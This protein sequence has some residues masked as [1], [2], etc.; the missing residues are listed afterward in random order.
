VDCHIDSALLQGPLKLMH[1]HAISPQTGDRCVALYITC[2]L[3]DFNR[4]ITANCTKLIR[5]MTS[6][7][8]SQQTATGAE[9]NTRHRRLTESEKQTEETVAAEPS[10]I[11]CGS[12]PR[13]FCL[14]DCCNIHGSGSSREE[15]LRTCCE[16][17]SR[18]DHIIY[19]Q[20]IQVSSVTT[21]LKNSGDI[22][23]PLSRWKGILHARGPDSSQLP[24]LGNAQESSDRRGHHIRRTCAS[25]DPPPPVHRNGN[26]SL[27]ANRRKPRLHKQRQST[28]DRYGDRLTRRTLCTQNG[29]SR[30][31][32]I[33]GKHDQ[34]SPQWRCLLA[35]QAL[36]IS[37]QGRGCTAAIAPWKICQQLCQTCWAEISEQKR[38]E[39][40]SLLRLDKEASL[41]EQ[42][43]RRKQEIC[44]IRGPGG[45]PLRIRL[46]FPCFP[47]I[48]PP[49]GLKTRLTLGRDGLYCP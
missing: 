19:Q 30:Q 45:Q 41:T 22:C 46:H 31:I 36:G 2:G 24:S 47:R 32:T 25:H 10:R 44:C 9:N 38:L 3:D 27:Q 26:D 21:S 8:A 4:H 5:Y 20:D 42:A 11:I 12:N 35:V 34:T 28:P 6:L 48:H 18:R 43:L 1:E 17:C 15:S 33:R 13:P 39:G 49:N 7:R 40:D 16:G 37:I 23:H 29:V 14:G